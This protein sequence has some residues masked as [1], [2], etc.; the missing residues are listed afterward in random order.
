VNELETIEAVSHFGAP[1]Y[2]H[3]SFNGINHY[4]HY[5]RRYLFLMTLGGLRIAGR[6]RFA[7]FLR[8]LA[9]VEG[10]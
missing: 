5:S 1:V 4:K 3:G 6:N 7:R 9:R 10:H 2:V 8:T